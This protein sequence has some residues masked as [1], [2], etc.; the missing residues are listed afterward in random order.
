MS[1]PPSSG[2]DEFGLGNLGFVVVRS[3][4]FLCVD[5]PWSPEFHKEIAKVAK[6]DGSG[7]LDS[8][9][10]RSATATGH[11]FSLRS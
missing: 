6:M 1:W 3:F 4:A 9:V 2:K 5:R 10:V 11:E 8:V 7:N